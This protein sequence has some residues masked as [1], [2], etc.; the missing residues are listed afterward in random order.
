MTFTVIPAI[1][2]PSSRATPESG[3]HDGSETPE[4]FS[5]HFLTFHRLSSSKNRA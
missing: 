2:V 3:K 5:F 1:M 4:N